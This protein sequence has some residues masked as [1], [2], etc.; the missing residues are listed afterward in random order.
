MPDSQIVRLSRLLELPDC[1]RY[2]AI[3]TVVL[4]RQIATRTR[5]HSYGCMWQLP[6]ISVFASLARFRASRLDQI[7]NYARLPDYCRQIGTS[8]ASTTQE[9]I[10]KF[11]KLLISD[12][13]EIYNKKACGRPPKILPTRPNQFWEIHYR[14]KLS[15]CQG[16][17]KLK[18]KFT[19][20]CMP[21]N[22]NKFNHKTTI[23]I[24]RSGSKQMKC[25]WDR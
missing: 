14:T 19:S 3:R 9:Y 13:V 10:R 7:A 5:L 21:K 20:G 6:L 11:I 25:L 18:Y 16:N 12:Q 22:P 24:P 17:P 1:P 2:T 4:H 15:F 8:F 23:Y